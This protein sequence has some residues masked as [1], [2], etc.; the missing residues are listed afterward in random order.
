MVNKTSGDIAN[1]FLGGKGVP[2]RTDVLLPSHLV[3]PY[4]RAGKNDRADAKA[5]LEAYRS[6]E[7]LSVPTKSIEKH[8][9]AALNHLRS[10]WLS[11]RTARVNALRGIS[12]RLCR[13]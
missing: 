4:R 9:L 13:P 6:E 8:P 2:R 7:I 3:R 5:L 10:G 12:R 11:A 1:T